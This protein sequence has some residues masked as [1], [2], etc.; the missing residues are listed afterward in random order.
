MEAIDLATLVAV[1]IALIEGLKGFFKLDGR[2]A[3]LIGLAYIALV[4]V[5]ETYFAEVAVYALTIGKIWLA[6][7]GVYE[8]G[9]RSGLVQ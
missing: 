9:K 1:S 3:A 8:F 2:I 6:A 4:V 7:M 5:G